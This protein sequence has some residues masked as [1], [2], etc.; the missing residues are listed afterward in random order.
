MITKIQTFKG[1]N[2]SILVDNNFLFFIKSI[3]SFILSKS[4][5]SKSGNLVSFKAQIVFSISSLTRLFSISTTFQQFQTIS[6]FLYKVIKTFHLEFKRVS[7]QII[8]SFFVGFI[9]FS[10]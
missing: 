7:S 2:S 4:L 8:K 9:E 10:K 5:T 6:Q 3:L 1:F